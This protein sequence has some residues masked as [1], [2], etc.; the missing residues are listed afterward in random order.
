MMTDNTIG[1]MIGMGIVFVVMV[2]IGFIEWRLKK[3]DK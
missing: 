2:L 1:L 3:D